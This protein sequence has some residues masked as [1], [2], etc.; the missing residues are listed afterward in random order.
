[1]ETEIIETRTSKVWLGDDGIIRVIKKEGSQ[2]HVDDAKETVQAI[3]S[4]TH[5]KKVPAL[6]DIRNIKSQDEDALEYYAGW[7]SPMSES[8]VALLINSNV[9]EASTTEFLGFQRPVL[10]TRVFELEEDALDWLKG[11]L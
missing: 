2:E 4:I 10:P 3:R 7:T 6:V 9:G 8:A 11:F 1:M 5:E